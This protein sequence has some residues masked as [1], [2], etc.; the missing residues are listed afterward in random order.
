MILMHVLISVWKN[1]INDCVY[2]D[3]SNNVNFIFCSTSTGEAVL[4]AAS[5]AVS[6]LDAAAMKKAWDD[7]AAQYISVLD[8]QHVALPDKQQFLRLLAAQERHVHVKEVVLAA[9]GSG[10]SVDPP[11]LQSLLHRLKTGP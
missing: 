8:M 6:T 1:M 2:E 11:E 5:G 3:F 4:T 10:D 7:G 9:L